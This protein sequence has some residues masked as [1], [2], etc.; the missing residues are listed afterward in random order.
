M[1]NTVQ[2]WR[3]YTAELNMKSLAFM[4]LYLAATSTVTKTTDA[5]IKVTS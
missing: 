2:D 3:G 1:G 5:G 4:S